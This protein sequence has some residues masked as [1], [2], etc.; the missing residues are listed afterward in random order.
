MKS[1]RAR[2]NTVAGSKNETCNHIIIEGHGNPCPF[3]LSHRDLMTTKSVTQRAIA[4]RVTC[5]DCS[6][7]TTFLDDVKQKYPSYFCKPVP[8][9]GVVKPKFLIVGLA[10]GLHGANRTGR[11]FTGDDAGELLFRTIHKFG[12]ADRVPSN[13]LDDSVKLIG[14]RITNAVKCLPPQ[15]KPNTSEIRVCN[16]YLRSELAGTAPQSVILALGGIAH[17]A[18]LMAAG[19]K[20]SAIKFAHG[21]RHFLAGDRVLFDSYHC[22]RY[23]IN[24]RRLTES[25]FHDVFQAICADLNSMPAHQAITNRVSI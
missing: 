16:Q 19:L 13:P 18:V 17:S 10:P 3:V 5:R 21:A 14:C 6:R 23:N 25:M 22:S 9:F 7:L 8:S 2:V 15:N 4:Y 20:P 11:P 1:T 24:T 12:F